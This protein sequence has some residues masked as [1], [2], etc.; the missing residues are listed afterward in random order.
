ME[1][2]LFSLQRLRERVNKQFVSSYCHL[3]L[4]CWH[5]VF[6]CFRRSPIR[7]KQMVNRRLSH[8]IKSVQ[9][10]MTDWGFHHR[11]SLA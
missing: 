10:L 7:Q 4:S 9:V 2:Y 3:S 8:P 5:L 1:S 11:Y 6:S